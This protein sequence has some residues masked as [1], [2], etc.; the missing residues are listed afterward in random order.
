MHML[1]NWA[2]H[3]PDQAGTDVPGARA[4]SATKPPIRKQSSRSCSNRRHGRPS[5]S[6][7]Q[8]FRIS[9]R[10]R[11]ARSSRSRKQRRRTR[12]KQSTGSR[13]RL[14]SRRRS[15]GRSESERRARSGRR[16]RQVSR[17]RRRRVS[18]NSRSSCVSSSSGGPCVPQFPRR[19]TLSDCGPEVAEVLYP[20]KDDAGIQALWKE[21]RKSALIDISLAA[22]HRH[23]GDCLL[24]GYVCCC[25]LPW[26]AMAGI[27]MA[28]NGLPWPLAYKYVWIGTW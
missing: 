9:R 6:R 18:S 3:E 5:S 10:C 1:D 15:N 19:Y 22:Y 11:H 17:R 20:S 26:Q 4:K 2:G 8:R 25:F 14:N 28:S 13:Q 23:L 7:G 12:S 16:R 24:V 27:P 21:L